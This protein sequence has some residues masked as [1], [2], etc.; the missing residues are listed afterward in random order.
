MAK[1]RIKRIKPHMVYC[2]SLIQQNHGEAIDGHGWCKWNVKS[3]SFEYVDLPNEYGYF[4]VE[5]KNGTPTDMSKMPNKVRLR[6]FAG[7]T[8][9]VDVKKFVT[10]L[11]KTKDVQELSV[12]NYTSPLKNKGSISTDIVG[13][14]HDVDYQNSLLTEYILSTDPNI[15]SDIL[16]KVLKLNAKLNGEVD[17]DLLTKLVQWEPVSLAFD[18]LFTYGES[19]FIDFTTLNGTVGLFAPNA[20]GKSS[21][22][23][24]ICFA[25]YD[26]TPRTT[27]ATN[28]M[29]TRKDKCYVKF[30]FKLNDLEYVIE[31][32]G[33]K[34]KKSEV[35]IDVDFYRINADGTK[36]SL[37]GEE[38]RYTNQNI[39]AYV[40]DF[41][42][43][44]LTA[45]SAQGQNALFIDRGQSDR[46][47]LLSQFMG[48]TIFDK[49]ETL[50]LSESKE[51]AGAIKQF[52]KDDSF[53]QTL[54]DVQA[55]IDTL[56]SEYDMSEKEVAI[57]T[58]EIAEYDTKVKE[59]LEQIHPTSSTIVDVTSIEL[60]YR[61]AEAKRDAFV[62]TVSE[63]QMDELRDKI[64]RGNEKLN[65]EYATIEQ[66][67]LA[68]KSASADVRSAEETVKRNE[69]M[70][71]TVKKNAAKL[72]KYE[73]DPSCAMCLKN[74]AQTISQQQNLAN[75]ITEYTDAVHVATVELHVLSD[76]LAALGDVEAR[77][78]KKMLGIQW[79]NDRNKDLAQMEKT[80]TAQQKEYQA[81][82]DTIELHKRTIEKYY[83]EQDKIVQNLAI[84]T[85][86]ATLNSTLTTLK[87][88]LNRW[89]LKSQDTAVATKL[90][91]AEKKALLKK[92]DDVKELE[93]TYKAYEYY[94]A[95][96]CRD[97][98]PYK[99]ISDVMPTIQQAVNQILSQMVDFS[100]SLELD[101]KNV[102][103]KIIYDQNRNW[104]LELAS[105]MEKFVSG[106][107]IRVALMNVCALPKSNF[108]IADEGFGVLDAEKLG[109]LQMLFDFLKTQFQF[110]IVISHLDLLRDLVDSRIDI[111]RVDGYSYINH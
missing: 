107:A 73:Y 86:I 63:T 102:N 34:N 91:M 111:K 51:I 92:M 8:D 12:S 89:K 88:T 72:A 108:L 53:S 60:Q 13:D 65:T 27:K 77:Y 47:D 85:E 93:T 19:N 57:V 103:G 87:S 95:A 10:L 48:L 54:I 37:N 81:L 64:A 25:L 55:A 101:G 33:S 49:L 28:I 90:K 11:R 38:R 70:L 9:E 61:N 35:K 23:D 14:V 96:V 42:D 32:K 39:R 80:R 94:L 84:R 1:I 41:E 69:L 15:A 18:N 74:G 105:G 97:G 16:E 59:K 79:I 26:R 71:D 78:N 109:S 36:T 62:F 82:L 3:R 98:I 24:A 2:S 83:E 45:L 66:E 21:I 29:N 7:D 31:R 106:L 110:I 56:S 67:Y 44:I 43:F 22:P 58:A 99:L 46:K 52:K 30:V 20:Y 75:Q 5:L 68:F 100:V 17:T 40:G 6:L 104:A 4:T 76:K 50:A